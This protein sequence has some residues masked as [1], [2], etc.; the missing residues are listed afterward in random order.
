[1]RCGKEGHIEGRAVTSQDAHN[2]PARPELVLPAA[3]TD[4]HTASQKLRHG[5]LGGVKRLKQHTLHQRMHPQ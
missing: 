2:L 3:L 1:M 5:V 4:L